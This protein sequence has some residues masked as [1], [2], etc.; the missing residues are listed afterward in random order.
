MDLKQECITM[1]MPLKCIV[2]TQKRPNC[3]PPKDDIFDN[4]IYLN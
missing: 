1:K 4:K 2:K 3:S